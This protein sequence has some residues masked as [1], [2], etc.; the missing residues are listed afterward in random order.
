MISKWAMIVF[1][2]LVAIVFVVPLPYAGLL[3]AISAFI[4]G[5]ALIFGK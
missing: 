4:A 2:L 5:I 1:F 3:M